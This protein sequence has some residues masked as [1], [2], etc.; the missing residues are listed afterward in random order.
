[1]NRI[2]SN[3]KCEWIMS[4]KDFYQIVS[5]DGLLSILFFI[6]YFICLIFGFI[7]LLIKLLFYP[8]VFIN[9]KI[10]IRFQAKYIAMYG[11]S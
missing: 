9:N 5:E 7:G 4:K 6:A 1:M 10:K 8:L 11:K 2:I 3:F